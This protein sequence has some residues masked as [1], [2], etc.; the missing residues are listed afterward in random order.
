MPRVLIVDDS[1]TETYKFKETLEKYG[2]DIITADNGAG[3]NR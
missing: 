1:P 2:F 3:S